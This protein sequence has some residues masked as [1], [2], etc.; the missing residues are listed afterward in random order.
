M[1]GTIPFCLSS[2]LKK[3]TCRDWKIKVPLTRHQ[4]D[5]TVRFI[6]SFELIENSVVST[7]IVVSSRVVWN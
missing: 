5:A 3:K 6:H 4:Q 7:I 2:I 1:P